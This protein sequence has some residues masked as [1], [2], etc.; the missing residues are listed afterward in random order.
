MA[1]STGAGTDGGG[2]CGAGGR[3]RGIRGGF[4]S[5]PWRLCAWPGTAVRGWLRG[6]GRSSGG[7]GA[8]GRPGEYPASV[9][10]CP[11]WSFPL[12]GGWAGGWFQDPKWEVERCLSEDQPRGEQ[13]GG[14]AVLGRKGTAAGTGWRSFPWQTWGPALGRNV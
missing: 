8:A 6:S 10:C 4:L 2:Q 3:G 12:D 9:A 11:L 5:S 7:A 1:T 14:P 13:S